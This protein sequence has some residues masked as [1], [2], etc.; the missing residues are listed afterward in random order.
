MELKTHL[1]E[2]NICDAKIQ[3]SHKVS[4]NYFMMCGVSGSSDVLWVSGS[5]LFL[6]KCCLFQGVCE[7]LLYCA[8][9]CEDYLN[10]ANVVSTRLLAVLR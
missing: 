3:C 10:A 9:G 4:W 8:I 2:E 6:K 7:K 5:S 1:G